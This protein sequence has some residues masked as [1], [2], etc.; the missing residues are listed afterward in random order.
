MLCKNHSLPQ[1][2]SITALANSISC[3]DGRCAM[4]VLHGIQQLVLLYNVQWPSSALLRALDPSALLLSTI[5]RCSHLYSPAIGRL[6]FGLMPDTLKSLATRFGAKVAL[7]TSAEHARFPF[8]D[9]PT[10]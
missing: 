10:L 8:A 4:Q 5:A 9:T 3:K 2:V 1:C 7:T 6:A